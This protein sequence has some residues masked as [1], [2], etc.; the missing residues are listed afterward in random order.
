[1]EGDEQE[2]EFEFIEIEW[3]E[4]DHIIEEVGL[5]GE[6]RSGLFFQRYQVD[7]LLEGIRIKGKD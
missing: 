7:G 1:M 3:N 5:M 6:E 2:E 4:N